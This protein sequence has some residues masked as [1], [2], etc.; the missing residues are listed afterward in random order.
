M[1]TSCV[2]LRRASADIGPLTHSSSFVFAPQA[3]RD[4]GSIEPSPSIQA[5]GNP[6]DVTA[7]TAAMAT[8]VRPV[9]AEGPGTSMFS[10]PQAHPPP[11]AASSAEI[12]VGV[13][14]LLRTCS[15]ARLTRPAGI[16]SS[17]LAMALFP[18]T[19]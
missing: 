12:P 15:E 2:D 5:A 14:G 3:R 8:V 16:R 19:F 7:Q 6:D 1:M 9:D 18:G 10:L 13:T 11:R 17:S 4:G